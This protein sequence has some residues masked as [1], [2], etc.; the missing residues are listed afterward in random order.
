MTGGPTAE[1]T[2]DDVATAR[3]VEPPAAQA[4]AVLVAGAEVS[5]RAAVVLVGAA[6]VGAAAVS[7]AVVSTA[8]VGVAGR[9]PRQPRW[10][11]LPCARN[12]EIVAPS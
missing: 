9:A 4:V 8:A 5:V 1:M 6:V 7:A 12:R 3:T 11:A 2:A 10:F